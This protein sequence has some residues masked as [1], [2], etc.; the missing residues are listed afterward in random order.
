MQGYIP[1]LWLEHLVSTESKAYLLRVAITALR[2]SESQQ[3]SNTEAAESLS[4]F[5]NAC[6]HVSAEVTARV[7]LLGCVELV[8]GVCNPHTSAA[9]TTHP[10]LVAVSHLWLNRVK[11]KIYP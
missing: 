9:S 2:Q 8:P 6:A 4:R 1:A 3:L 5:R 7:Y 10:H 11:Y